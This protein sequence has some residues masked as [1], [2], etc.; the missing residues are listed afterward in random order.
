MR[1]IKDVEFLYNEMKYSEA[2]RECG[3]CGKPERWRKIKNLKIVEREG[4][5]SS[6]KLK[7][8]TVRVSKRTTI[9]NMVEV[10]D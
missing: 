2:C 5:T 8:S 10:I 6:V 3:G 1:K 7:A 4:Q 9:F